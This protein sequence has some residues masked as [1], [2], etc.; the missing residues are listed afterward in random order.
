MRYGWH[1]KCI[2]ISLRIWLLTLFLN[3]A[4]YIFWCSHIYYKKSAKFYR[5]KMICNE[6][7]WNLFK[8][9]HVPKK[10]LKELSLS[11]FIMSWLPKST[12]HKSNNVMIYFPS[13]SCLKVIHI[14][15][16][17]LISHV[18]ILTFF[19]LHT[20]F[21][22]SESHTLLSYLHSYFMNKII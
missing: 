14:E 16:T 1:V 21:P 15:V 8:K 7:W 6:K 3:F 19:T 4:F 11:Y 13:F 12:L 17:M 5:L 22:F 10:S 20:C 2:V 9:K 18:V